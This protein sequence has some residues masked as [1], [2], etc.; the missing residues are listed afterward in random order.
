MSIEGFLFKTVLKGGKA[1]FG[2]I[3]DRHEKEHCKEFVEQYM[4]G[5]LN[6]ISAPVLLKK[7]EKAYFAETAEIFQI[8]K[9]TLTHRAF[10]GTRI[11]VGG[12]P[13]FLG[14]STPLSQTFKVINEVGAGDF[15]ITD[16]RV[17]VSSQQATYS[18]LLDNIVD[19]V[20]VEDAL[21]IRHDGRNSGRF[22]KLDKPLLAA[23]I[24]HTII[25][26]KNPEPLQAEDSIK[27][28]KERTKNNSDDPEAQMALGGAY[29]KE[30]KYKEAV[31]TFKKAIELGPLSLAQAYFY[32]GFSYRNLGML[33][34]AE[35]SF[36]EAAR[37]DPANSE[38][39]EY[40]GIVYTE[41][42]KLKEAVEALREAIQIA[43]DSVEAHYNLG[44]TYSR[45]WNSGKS[46]VKVQN[47]LINAFSK[48][49]KLKPGYAQA[50]LGLG[51]VYVAVKD[52]EKA[53]SQYNEL[54]K[55]DIAL[56]KQLYSE[57][58]K[59]FD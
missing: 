42:G 21:E 25:E 37:V 50:Y 20:L 19:L 6:P 56:S 3:S 16:K 26:G 44:V 38:A 46:D 41:Q 18:V 1:L 58:K 52:K 7:G 31:Q 13:I 54:R 4:S 15:V 35:V 53:L 49:I 22:Y 5:E 9:E 23:T 39:Y 14:G 27:F 59:Q 17:I 43:P 45:L 36:K 10:A 51:M 55:L 28:Y 12:L 24:I 2:F 8:D 57:I 29:I 34:E 30:G 40:L 48:A 32:I 47:E 11:N 33:K